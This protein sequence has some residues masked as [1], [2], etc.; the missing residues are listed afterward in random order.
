MVCMKGGVPK[1]KKHMDVFIHV[2]DSLN[3]RVYIYIERESIQFK[4]NLYSRH[5]SSH[6]VGNMQCSSYLP[7]SI[8]TTLWFEPN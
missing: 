8:K 6:G 2:V 7:P 3:H 5:S 4:I 1:G